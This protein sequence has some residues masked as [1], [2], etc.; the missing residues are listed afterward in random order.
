MSTSPRS[1]S[2]MSSEAQDHRYP[3]LLVRVVGRSRLSIDDIRRF[4]PSLQR[5]PPPAHYTSPSHGLSTLS[6]GT[7]GRRIMSHPPQTNPGIDLHPPAATVSHPSPPRASPWFHPPLWFVIQFQHRVMSIPPPSLRPVA[8]CLDG[9]PP[10]GGNTKVLGT[11][12]VD[13]L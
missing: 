3:L 11:S 9:T 7:L 2:G 6:V 1:L 4:L 12:S 13:T 8:S 10:S 5:S